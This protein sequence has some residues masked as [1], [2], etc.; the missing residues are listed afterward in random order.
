MRPQEAAWIARVLDQ[1]VL[2][3]SSGQT[4]LNLGS[5]TR[6]AREVSKPY[7]QAQTI[8]PLL[9]AGWRVVHSDLLEGEGI[10]LSGSIFDAPFQQRLA[11]LKPSL[12]YFCNVL[13]HL[14]VNLRDQ[15]P[16]ILESIVAPG[17]HLLITVPHSYPYHADPIDTLYRPSPAEVAALFPGWTVVAQAALEAGSYR[18]EFM[19]GSLGKR[20]R[21][22]A[23]MAFPFVR[24]R[25]WWSHAHRFA[26]LWKPYV[27]TCV[28]LRKPA[29]G[30]APQM[31]SA[32]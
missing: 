10:D 23:R 27:Q 2:A 1:H 30:T 28:L 21:K 20:I 19:A 3:S 13:E 7:V 29:M 25:R 14:P 12:V 11:G 15:V 4:A 5:G 24:P 8:E 26:W 18:E 22:V 32:D 9:R 6:K 16:A 31:P 17:G